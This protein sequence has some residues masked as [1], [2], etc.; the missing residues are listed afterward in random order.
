MPEQAAQRQPNDQPLQSSAA[1]GTGR[2]MLYL[3][4]AQV[5]ALAIPLPRIFEAV[6]EGFRKLALGQVDAPPKTA[7]HPTADTFFHSL[8][9]YIRG[10][11]LAGLKWVSGFPENCRKGLPQIAGLMI[12]NDATT[13]MPVAV[14]DCGWITAVR[15][16]A[17][18]A[19]AAKYLARPDS[20]TLAILGCGV[21]G[22]STTLA[23]DAA[24]PLQRIRAY[25]KYPAAATRRPTPG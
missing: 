19:L 17:A 22:R 16:G 14:M 21:Q 12:L 18:T 25:D 24:L 4:D 7:V 11:A 9:G 5:Q 2:E 15:T 3:A 23:L 13:G 10:Q 8:P 1:R 6:E 20:T